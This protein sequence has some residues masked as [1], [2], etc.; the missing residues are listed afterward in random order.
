[1]CVPQAAP[2]KEALCTAIE[3]D[4]AVPPSPKRSEMH[5]W[6]GRL[7][8]HTLPAEAVPSCEQQNGTVFARMVRC[9]FCIW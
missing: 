9:N 6:W 8:F 3:D 4:G 1:M 5:A 2:I 7:H